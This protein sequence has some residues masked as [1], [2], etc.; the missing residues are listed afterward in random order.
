M[1]LAGI[2]EAVEKGQENAQNCCKN[3]AYKD[4]YLT[5]I[6]GNIRNYNSIQK[7]KLKNAIARQHFLSHLTL[8]TNFVH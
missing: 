6:Q 3:I 1:T 7:L 2:V 8:L 5:K 4:C